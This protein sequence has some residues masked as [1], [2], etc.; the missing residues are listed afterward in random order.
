[1]K[2]FAKNT[3]LRGVKA[4]GYTIS[5]RPPPAPPRE[6]APIFDDPL[7]AVHYYN[8][9]KSAAFNCPLEQTRVATG[10]SYS[11][12][13]W[14]PWVATLQEF[15]EGGSATYQDSVFKA[16]H[17]AWQPKTGAEAVAGFTRHSPPGMSRLP[18]RAASMVPW[19]SFSFEEIL[20]EVRRWTRRDY[21]ALGLDFD[22]DP[23]LHGD[24]M[25]GPIHAAL[26]DME[27]LR[28]T[29]VFASIQENGYQRKGDVLVTILKRGSELRFLK[30]GGGMHRTAAVAA[31][32]FDTI[33][34]TFRRDRAPLFDV[35]DVDRWPKVVSGFWTREA[36][37]RY[38][39][40][41]FDFDSAAW[42]A[43]RG[44][45]LEQR[46]PEGMRSSPGDDNDGRGV[47]RD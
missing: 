31:L 41:L 36:A 1:M 45:L 34:A 37:V 27:Y 3:V 13:G 44:L 35:A 8:G 20:E 2:K 6:L 32:G 16:Y 42:A 38:V 28:L 39:D 24:N 10:F 17:D 47:G 30:T 26:G 4:F 21:A 46:H 33:P 5:R 40:H 25:I 7:D 18:P 11:A 23:A 22:Y 12:D 9:G 14:H 15:A 43:E 29:R 19:I